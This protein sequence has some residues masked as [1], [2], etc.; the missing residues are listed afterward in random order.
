MPL[1]NLFARASL[2]RRELS[3]IRSNEQ[4]ML[5]S[6]S[7][8]KESVHGTHAGSRATGVGLHLQNR[9]VVWTS[10]SFG[11]AVALSIVLVLVGEIGLD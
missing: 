8:N 4:R 10:V 3:V 2:E 7:F 1:L 6:G 5:L 11:G 9:S